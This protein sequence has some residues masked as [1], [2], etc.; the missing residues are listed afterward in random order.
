MKDIKDLLSVLATP[1]IM[2]RIAEV[3]K[4]AR[5][6]VWKHLDIKIDVFY[7]CINM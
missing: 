2:R 3:E 7:S 1:E 5:A 4:N 6:P